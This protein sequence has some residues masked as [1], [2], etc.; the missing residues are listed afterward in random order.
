MARRISITI[1]DDIERDVLNS[2]HA[3]QTL[4]AKEGMFNKALI[5]YVRELKTRIEGLELTIATLERVAASRPASA[6]PA[7]E[8]AAPTEDWG[9]EKW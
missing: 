8:A 3:E 6:A 4:P 1:P 7:P 5:A 9:S 2:D